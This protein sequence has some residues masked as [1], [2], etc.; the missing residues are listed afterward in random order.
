[1]AD[2]SFDRDTA[3]R[4]AELLLAAA[5]PRLDADAMRRANAA[6]SHEGGIEWETFIPLARQHGVVSLLYRHLSAGALD[7]SKVPDSAAAE[8][9]RVTGDI[10]RRCLLLTGE[11]VRLLDEFDRHGIRVVSLKG[12]ILG[13]QVYGSIAL[14]RFNDLDL[15]V[16]TDDV[17][18][19]SELLLRLGYA[20]LKSESSDGLDA[21]RRDPSH[22]HSFLAAT[23]THRVELHY[24][25]T[26]PVAGRRLT[27]ASIEA[28]L[29]R[30]PFHTTSVWMLRP[31]DLLV[32]LC[33]HGT[34]HLWER[35]EWVGAVAELARG[36]RIA[37]WNR[38][39]TVARVFSAD[40]AVTAGLQ[41]VHDLFGVPVS[42]LWMGGDADAR[43]AARSLA[44]RFI[45]DP[46]RSPSATERLAYHVRTEAGAASRR[47]RLWSTLF[48]PTTADIDAIP[49]PRALWALYYVL[50][51]AR[52][53]LR[54][55]KGLERSVRR[56]A[57]PGS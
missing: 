35:I 50:R 1:M 21:I 13:Q 9:R 53:T 19:A 46:S 54:W 24:Y 2:E 32:Y 8:L 33:L 57:P 15:L 26:R 45:A 11:L 40:R 7:I 30:L 10:A 6:M 39:A 22:H 29:E 47:A 20:N 25:L 48:V 14:R 37:D 4:A 12:P 3:S 5:T 34:E 18:R 52:L 42:S 55:F 16:A 43:A 38:V 51:P 27:L 36:D 23:K 56:R 49:L 41:L 28:G 31:E 17:G 44:A